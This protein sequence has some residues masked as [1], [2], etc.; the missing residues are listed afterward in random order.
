MGWGGDALPRGTSQAMGGVYK[1]PR[2]WFDASLSS[3]LEPR[4]ASEAP[5]QPRQLRPGARARRRTQSV[6]GAGT[7]PQHPSEAAHS[8]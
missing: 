2:E 5:D 8:R 3:A 7:T 6:R 1:L 4:Q